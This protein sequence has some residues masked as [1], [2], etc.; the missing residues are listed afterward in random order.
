[1]APR[2]TLKKTV[3]L[4]LLSGL[5]GVALLVLL[6]DPL[7]RMA[8]ERGGSH[9]LETRVELEEADVTWFPLG[10]ELTGLGVVDPDD[11]YVDAFTARTIGFQV[12]PGPL[13][14][15]KVVI[16]KM[17]LDGVRLAVPRSSSGAL[18]GQV[19]RSAA[20]DEDTGM[21]ST[22]DFPDPKEVLAR[23]DLQSIDRAKRL[24]ADV[25]ATRAKWQQRMQSLP[26]KTRFEGYKTRL[27]AAGSQGKTGLVGALSGGGET[28]KISQEIKADLAAIRTAQADFKADV[29]RLK[30]DAKEVAALPANEAKRLAGQFGPDA[31]GL[32]NVM[33]LILGPQAQMWTAT[34]LDWYERLGPLLAGDDSD[35]AET[36]D[37]IDT[38]GQPDLLIRLAQMSIEL[39]NGTVAG[40]VQNISSDAVLSGL[41]TTFEFAALK[42]PLVEAFNLTGA[43]DRVQPGAAKDTAKWLV[44]GLKLSDI[45]LAEKLGI[46]LTLASGSARI[47]GEALLSGGTVQSTLDGLL[48]D[49]QFVRQGTDGS[50]IAKAVAG[51]LEST[52]KVGLNATISG[53]LTQPD[54]AVSSDLD[55]QLSGQIRSLVAD[56]RKAF[57]ADIKSQ[58]AEKVKGPLADV[59]QQMSN[60]G[61]MG[62]Q[63]GA[64]QQQG[65]QL[66]TSAVPGGKK[67]ALGGVGKLFGR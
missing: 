21:L 25:K 9:A 18:P 38:S 23:A 15:G 58:L 31:D 61:G 47:T 64:L 57:E 48:N 54:V 37:E 51:V 29:A 13:L 36:A 16:D 12:E 22:L 52:A 11:P 17:Q 2:S 20:E 62:G 24:S 63:L 44:E 45:D 42:W 35:T 32:K 43:L 19:A 40:T 1:M 41:P 10:L 53:L 28:L 5:I 50:A 60:L 6:I 55:N 46:P 26:D 33:G 7:V 65:A 39:E 27:K 30:G 4:V 8:I 59:Q 56:K 66:L 3:G 34:A 14:S 67:G 49:G